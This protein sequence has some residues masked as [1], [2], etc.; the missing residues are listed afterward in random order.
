MGQ[1]GRGEIIGSKGICFKIGNTKYCSFKNYC[2][3]VYPYCEY[4]RMSVFLI[5]SFPFTS[6]MSFEFWQ[7]DMP[8]YVF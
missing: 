4:M 1:I 8:K 7:T 2:S 6:L 3:S 5:M